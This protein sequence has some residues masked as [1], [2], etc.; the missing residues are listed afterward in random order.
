MIKVFDVRIRS[1]VEQYLNEL[2]ALLEIQKSGKKGFTELIDYGKTNPS[3]SQGQFKYG[4]KFIV[5]K[6]LGVTFN[7][8]L[9]DN[10]K[11]IR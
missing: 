9:N 11:N 4:E 10:H 3:H 2:D 8:V 7:K 1:N 5:M 6:K